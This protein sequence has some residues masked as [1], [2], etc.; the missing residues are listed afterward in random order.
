MYAVIVKE[1]MQVAQFKDITE[2]TK[3]LGISSTTFWRMRKKGNI[4]FEND[5]Y[6][7]KEPFYK[8]ERSNRGVK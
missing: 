3:F 6:V 1:T 4:Y 5:K 8:Q 2:L 7:M